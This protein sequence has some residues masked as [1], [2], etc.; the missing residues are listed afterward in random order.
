V[1]LYL[2]AVNIFIL[3]K[4]HRLSAGKAVILGLLPLVLLFGLMFIGALAYFGMLSP[5]KFIPENCMIPGHPGHIDCN[6]FQITTD[7]TTVFTIDNSLGDE[8]MMSVT[9]TAENT[10]SPRSVEI[11]KGQEATFT[12]AGSPGTAGDIYRHGIVLNYLDQDGI[13]KTVQGDL[14]LRYR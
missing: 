8:N 10:C 9:A 6:N 13:N 12:C 7:G 14:Y 2:I 5:D 11:Y 4:V 3:M 1:G